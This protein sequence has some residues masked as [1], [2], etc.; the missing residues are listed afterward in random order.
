M[1]R[2]V[3]DVHPGVPHQAPWRT[4]TRDRARVSGRTA[5]LRGLR[6]LAVAQSSRAALSAPGSSVRETAPNRRGSG[7]LS[8]R[9][10]AGRLKI[11]LRNRLPEPKVLQSVVEWRYPRAHRYWDDCGKLIAKVERAFPGLVGQGLQ[12]DGFSFEGISEGLT[13]AKFYWDKANVSQV[14]RGDLGLPDAAA[15]FWR[16]VTDGLTLAEP[17]R[18]GHR[19]WLIF[20]TPSLEMA[21]RWLDGFSLWPFA[22]GAEGMGHPLASGCVLRTRLE[23]DGR[24]ARIEVNAGASWRCEKPLGLS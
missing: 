5:E 3:V 7:I 14:E 11:K 10:S 16:I 6:L 13:G 23:P 22:E 19:S 15:K 18:L 21:A 2:R 17:T 1:R 8:G 9:T 12:P 4:A 20:E 24:T